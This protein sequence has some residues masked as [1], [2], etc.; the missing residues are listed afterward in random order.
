LDPDGEILILVTIEDAEG[1]RN[2]DEI[3]KVPGL[4]GV[5][6]GT[7]DGAMSRFGRMSQPVD[8]QW[9]AEADQRVLRAARNAGIAVGTAPG[10]SDQAIS[11]AMEEGYTFIIGRGDNYLPFSVNDVRVRVPH[12]DRG[13]RTVKSVEGTAT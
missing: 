2:I 6:F 13:I 11:R 5:I 4:G 7:S 8:D 1:L 9:T 10:P 3:V 12:D